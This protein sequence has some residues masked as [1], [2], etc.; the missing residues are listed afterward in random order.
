MPSIAV[1]GISPAHSQGA[2]KESWYGTASKVAWAIL[3]VAKRHRVSVDD[4]TVLE[5]LVSRK[6]LRRRAKGVYTCGYT[7]RPLYVTE[8]A[9]A[10]DVA[11]G[12]P[13]NLPGANGG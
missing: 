3:H 4:V 8:T 1:E 5:C 10:D 11:A 13:D 2:R 7:I 6:Q 12:W 9:D